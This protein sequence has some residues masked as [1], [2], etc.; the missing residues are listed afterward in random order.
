MIKSVIKQLSI[1]KAYFLGVFSLIF[2][3]SCV[4]QSEK[5]SKEL[6]A[7]INTKFDES[8]TVV[9]K[10]EGDNELTVNTAFYNHFVVPARKKIALI[11]PSDSITIEIGHLAIPLEQELLINNESFVFLAFPDK[12]TTIE[13]IN[14]GNINVRYQKHAEINNYL[15]KSLKRDLFRVLIT[16]RLNDFEG[17]LIEMR[18]IIDSLKKS[19]LQFLESYE[20]TLPEW[21]TVR[22]KFNLKYKWEYLK[23][24][25]A[26]KW[27][28]TEEGKEVTHK[29]FEFLHTKKVEPSA[30]L[31]PYYYLFL[32]SAFFH[33]LED[34]YQKYDQ[35]YFNLT[36]RDQEKAR[37]S[38][39]AVDSNEYW[40]DDDS[41]EIRYKY[42][43]LKKAN[44]SL[45]KILSEL[46]AFFH[47][48]TDSYFSNNSIHTL[49]FYLANFNN[50][51]FKSRVESYIRNRYKTLK[52]GEKATFQ[53]VDKNR[54]E[55]K[56]SD[57]IGKVV[58]LSFWYPGCKPCFKEFPFELDILEKFKD[59]E[60]QL[61]NI[62]LVD[63][64]ENNQFNLSKVEV[65]GLNL[66][67]GKDQK[68]F[69]RKEFGVYYFPKYVIL[70]R[71]GK[72]RKIDGQRP[73]DG[74]LD[75]LIIK[76]LD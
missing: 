18:S 43:G 15:E 7:K 3:L 6:L 17:S 33:E 16:G 32:R 19:D 55:Y 61:I 36:Y 75:E 63:P 5:I 73:S 70:D 64:S 9:I 4:G 69:L 46:Y 49:N 20:E 34:I 57:F 29:D 41:I 59:K 62:C 1:S 45:P 76:F 31:S 51:S 25:Y 60:F 26:K 53:L 10:Y 35:K 23:E 42:Y 47:A 2:I 71:E 72:L 40:L 14:R 65:P 58:L 68:D 8:S 30:I 74:N 22:Q 28:N 67:P 38:L 27:I 13:I 12:K 48:S 56:A 39:G 50:E 24:R 21:F 66:Y 52:I 44:D 11:A 37:E 54:K